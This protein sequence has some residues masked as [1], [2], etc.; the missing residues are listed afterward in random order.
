MRIL[1]FSRAYTTHDRRF[2]EAIAARHE[3]W[4]LRLEDDAVSYEA[5]PVPRGVRVMEPL[6]A[7]VRISNPED[8]LSIVPVF[9]AALARA[10]PDMVHAGPIQSCAFLA[11]QAGFHPLLAISW[12]S[13]LLVDA[14]RDDNWN[15]S[16]RFA[17]QHSDMLATDC[18]EVS[19]A[20]HR[21]AGV[22]RERIVQFPWGVDI[23]AFR[24]G[25]DRPELR[26]KL[27]WEECAVAISTRSWE[28]VYGV[29]PLLESF[30]AAH[31]SQPRLRL[32]LAGD[33][34]LRPDVERLISAGGLERA[35]WLP[36]AVPND[37]LPDYFRAADFY[38]S[39]ARSDGSSISLLEAMATGL[40]VIATDRASN[41]EWIA[42]PSSGVL[43]PSGDTRAMAAALLA[44]ANLSGSRR[45]EIAACNRAIAGNRADWRRNVSKL[46][47]A[48]E[49]LAPH[50]GQVKS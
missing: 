48:Y 42:A 24:P 8:Y 33:G 26:C 22:G 45:R 39:F 36:G 7:G 47:A 32:I 27:G 25:T 31:Y 11:A 14:H 3:V 2:L 20:A 12:G 38:V 35:V 50:A 40:P 34:S 9:E 44:M 19:E 41:R 30:S 28:S 23:D 4:Y 16:T 1:Y 46:L 17:L 6:A 5:R 37:Q 43:V 21:V 10:R 49:V 13:D 18:D 29:L 15:R